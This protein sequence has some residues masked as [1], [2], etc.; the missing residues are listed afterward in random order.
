MFDQINFIDRKPKRNIEQKG[1][2]KRQRSEYAR[3]WDRYRER[4]VGR[5]SQKSIAKAWRRMANLLDGWKIALLQWNSLAIHWIRS[6]RTAKP[7]RHTHMTVCVYECA[8]V[9]RVLIKSKTCQIIK[10]TSTSVPAARRFK[11]ANKQTKKRE[12]VGGMKHISHPPPFVWPN[13]FRN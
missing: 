4:E 5:G 10:V 11:Q 12:S 1:D 3:E 2:S 8:G 6:L 9:R 13:S 7:I